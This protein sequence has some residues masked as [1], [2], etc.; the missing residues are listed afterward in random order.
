MAWAVKQRLVARDKLVLLM[1]A[2]Y[3]SNERGDCYPSIDLLCEE[4]GM[5]RNTIRTALA[6]LEE[7]GLIEVRQRSVEGV[8][9]S[10]VYRVRIDG[11]GQNLTQGGGSNSGRGVGQ[12]LTGGGS[13]FYPKPIKEPIKEP[14]KEGA[15]AGALPEWVPQAQ[16]SAFV[17][18][19]KRI[20]KPLTD[21]AI[22]LAV[23]EL[24]KL[25]KQGHDPARV[26][27]QSI[28]NCWQGLF[29]VRNRGGMDMGRI[30]ATAEAFATGGRK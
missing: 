10:N 26:L 24:D 9:L 23:G 12:N 11:V 21:R 8:N 16:W 15:R 29:A 28:L 3:A 19:R 4:C 5:T 18:M 6:S 22:D 30:N 1:L 27:D 2:N 20:R 13:K 17:D 25:R 14:G 7:A